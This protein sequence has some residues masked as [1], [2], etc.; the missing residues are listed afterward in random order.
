MKQSYLIGFDLGGTKMLCTVLDDELNVV[1]REKVKVGSARDNDS[2]LEAIGDA[3]KKALK[4]AKVDEDQLRAIGIAS[5][6][7]IDFENGIL[8]ETPNL[9]L[10]NLPL[11]DALQKEFGCSVLLENDVNAGTYGE[12]IRGAAVGF[13]HV[14]GIFPGTG[15]GGGLILDGKLY[16][17]SGGGAGEIGHITIE[18]DGPKCG[19]GN[20][21]CLEQMSSRAA[22]AKELVGLALTGQSKVVMEEAGTDVAKVKSKT[23]LKAVEAGE[24]AVIEVVKRAARYMGIGMAAAVNI[25]NPEILI[26]GGGLIEKLG[27]FYVEE[28]AESMR[29]HAMKGLVANVQVRQALLTDDAAV[30]GAAALALE[31]AQKETV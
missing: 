30:I 15:V 2:I 4:S 21:G 26:L 16:R 23:I 14:V 3:I 17:G 12:Y 22:I 28:A 29:A 10:S 7:P 6:G 19:C 13:R 9:H 25:F 8:L 27:D 18:P 31:E 11:R 1:G 20:Y 5:P 24:P